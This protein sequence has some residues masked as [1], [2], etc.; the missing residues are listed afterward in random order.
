MQISSFEGT[1]KGHI[2]KEGIRLS[3]ILYCIL[4]RHAQVCK[5]HVC[6]G[7]IQRHA[8]WTTCC[9]QNP[10][11]FLDG[12]L[13]MITCWA[14]E[15]F[16]LKVN[17]P[18]T[19]LWVTPLGHMYNH[20]VF[21]LKVVCYPKLLVVCTSTKFWET[22]QTVLG[23]KNKKISCKK[24]AHLGIGYIKTS[25]NCNHF[26]YRCEQIMNVLYCSSLVWGFPYTNQLLQ[27]LL[28]FVCISAVA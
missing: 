14:Q 28:Q 3:S 21:L 27:L 17:K 2:W 18:W 15:T 1:N 10:K 13:Y 7:G 8:F 5:R 16:C 24:C 19:G 22:A 25:N 6:K 20:T 11:G 12:L 9:A 4:C 26:E 23:V